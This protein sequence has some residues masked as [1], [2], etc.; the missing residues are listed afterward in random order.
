VT[1][2]TTTT[3]GPVMYQLSRTDM[4]VPP[5]LLVVISIDQQDEPFVVLT[6]TSI[7]RVWSDPALLGSG[8]AFSLTALTI[9]LAHE[10]GHYVACR[11]YGLPCTVPYFLPVP[12]T[13]G[14]VGAFIRIYAPIRSKRELFDV[15]VAGPIAGFVVLI[16]FLV[17]GVAHSQPVHLSAL[18][19]PSSLFA[20]GR[21]LIVELLARLFHG[22]LGPDVYL[23][24]HPV[25]LGAWLGLLATSLNLL[26]LGQLDG[27]HILYSVLGRRQRWTALPLWIGLA[28]LGWFWPGWW[29]WCVIVFVIGL[30]HPPVRDERTPLD[31]KRRLLAVLALVI[32]VLSFMP[33]PLAVIELP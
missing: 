15:G 3:L 12:L 18:Q 5:E 21:S 7:R 23:D 4:T 25:A 31:P 13:F 26:P 30:F 24:L 28:V 33:T 27:G 11:R 17:Y 22:P 2:F 19:G 6:P 1:L 14:T 10:L 9:L 29:A 20:P 16:P 32:F 8:L